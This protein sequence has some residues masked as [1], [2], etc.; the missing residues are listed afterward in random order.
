MKKN[1][2]KT[3]FVDG[4]NIQSFG[5][6]NHLNQ[7]IK[8]APKKHNNIDINYNVWIKKALKN[9]M[10]K[11]KNITYKSN[12]YGNLPT[13]LNLIWNLIVFRL[14]CMKNNPDNILSL[15]GLLFFK[16]KNATGIFQNVQPFLSK[17]N[18]INYHN[19]RVKVLKR[20]WEYSSKNFTKHIFHSQDSSDLIRSHF[21]SNR[22][23]EIIYHGVD[24]RFRINKNKILS[25][26]DKLEEKIKLNQKINFTYITSAY[27]YKNNEKIIESFQR[28]YSN[29]FNFHLNLVIANGPEL[30]SFK[31]T[32]N[33]CEFKSKISLSIDSSSKDIKN[34][35]HQETD[36]GVFASNF[37]SFGLILVEKM[38]SGLPIFAV[39][40]SCIPEIL[41]DDANYFSIEKSDSLHKE[42]ITNFNNYKNIKRKTL[43]TWERANLFR[44]NKSANKTWDFVLD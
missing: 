1:R 22:A 37:E 29:N 9:K 14:I 31:K 24:E 34:I 33:K 35:L 3:V 13:P 19:I 43:L 23:F 26:L 27:P 38:A 40:K 36:V 28:M 17:N 18:T 44:W 32:I 10:K 16:H 21:T 30:K 7:I 42:I 8:Y 5:G 41:G 25:K 15:G 12:F 20:L 11:S 6:V 39:E 4:M 2:V